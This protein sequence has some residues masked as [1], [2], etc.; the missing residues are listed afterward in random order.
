MLE[1]PIT[2]IVKKDAM[3]IGSKYRREEILDKTTNIDSGFRATVLWP[4]YLPAMY[5]WLKLYKGG[6]IADS[7]DNPT[8]MR[9]QETVRMGVISLPPVI[10]II[11]QRRWK[12]D[13]TNRFLSR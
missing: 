6:G 5:C 4:L 13:V 7:E 12:I 3:T 11:P 10:D 1:N 9:C 2:T 8:W